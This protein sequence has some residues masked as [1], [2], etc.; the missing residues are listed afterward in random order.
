MAL[1]DEID[2][3]GAR[4]IIVAAEIAAGAMLNNMGRGVALPAMTPDWATAR[5]IVECLFGHP[6]LRARVGKNRAARCD[7]AIMTQ[8]TRE[9]NRDGIASI[10]ILRTN[11]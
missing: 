9:P 3:V 8:Y 2:A 1:A 6:A 4:E 5:K 11:A 7:D 10:K